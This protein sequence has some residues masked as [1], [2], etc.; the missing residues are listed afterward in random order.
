MNKSP[1]SLLLHD[2]EYDGCLGQLSDSEKQSMVKAELA[3]VSATRPPHE[4]IA[5]FEILKEPFSAESGT[6]TRSMK[7]RR[8]V[9]MQKYAAEVEALKKRL[10]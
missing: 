7:V 10:R 2:F 3:K 6:L 1:I 9:V 8:P 4:R 5:A